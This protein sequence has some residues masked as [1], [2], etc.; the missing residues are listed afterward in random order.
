MGRAPESFAEAL[1]SGNTDR[2][3]GAIDEVEAVDA[4]ERVEQYPALF[5]ACYP[6]YDSDDGYVRQ[7]VVRFLRDAYP[8]LELQI[9]AVEGDRVDGYA[10]D[11]LAEIRSSLVEL[12]L[13]GLED[14]D[15]R[16]RTA[17]VDGF[18]TLGVALDAAGLDA[19]RAALVEALEDLADGLPE[20]KAEDA[21]S[22]KRS[23][24]RMGFVGGLMS[25]IEIDS[26]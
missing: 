24:E 2:V 13:E 4:T 9:A 20:E 15:G 12:L 3:N 16:V 7:A 6:V 18:E 25:D 5:D 17:A 21:E 10:T 8:M 1:A 19:E 23:V 22:A 26:P 14:D 11:D